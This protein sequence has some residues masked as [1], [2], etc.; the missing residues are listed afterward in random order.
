MKYSVVIPTKNRADTLRYTLSNVLASRRGEVEVIVHH[1]GRDEAT[2][3]VIAAAGD[4]RVRY[5]SSPEPLPMR[6][7]WE[8]ALA[9]ATGEF[10][11]V[12]GDDDALMP[13][14]FEV[15]DS[16]IGA[17]APEI[18]SWRPATYYWPSSHDEALAGR[19]MYRYHIDY[20]NIRFDSRYASRWLYRFKWH[21]S[22]MPMIYN[23]FVSRALVERVRSRL[24]RYFLLNSPDITSG[25]VNAAYS[26]SFLWSNYPLTVTGISKNSTGQRMAMQED[27]QIRLHAISEFMPEE[28]VQ[29]WVPENANLDFGIAVELLAL[30]EAL[31]LEAEGVAV[32]MLDVAE[33]LARHM[34]QYPQLEASRGALAAFCARHGL[35]C[36]ALA[37]RYLLDRPRARAHHGEVSSATECVM[38]RNLAD[39]GV[40]NISSA[41]QAIAL[42]LGEPRLAGVAPVGIGNRTLAVTAEPL[43]LS[44]SHTGNASQYLGSGWNRPEGFGAWACDYEARVELPPL[45]IPETSGCLRIQ[46]TGRGP[47]S[48]EMEF[49][50]SIEFAGS[51]RV[52]AAS[53]SA[54][55]PGGCE[56]IE[57][58][59]SRVPRARPIRIWFR[60]VELVNSALR[61]SG[62][63]N[64]PLGFGLERIT[65]ELVTEQ[66][67]PREPQ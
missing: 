36:D 54:L 63:D 16:L 14:A 21:Y 40:T 37:S 66:A 35:D 30:R 53:F 18:L 27:T 55:R 65:L 64:R 20:G 1:S 38:D 39:H 48:G 46:V 31:G 24:G 4:A 49:P 13:G 19:A 5:F 25:V 6:E 8:R 32:R 11:T 17:H 58:D 26:D 43:H 44:F 41:A 67:R 56:I 7:N 9:C 22:D 57:V 15:A 29:E 62:T 33:Y 23:S 12:I 47:I 50:F 10:V 52:H 34:H 61:G 42:Y 28:I 2:D 3:A 45:E 51:A 59:A 60:S